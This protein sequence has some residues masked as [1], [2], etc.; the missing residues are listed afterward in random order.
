[1]Q[2]CEDLAARGVKDWGEGIPLIALEG[3]DLDDDSACV[4]RLRGRGLSDRTGP[5]AGSLGALLGFSLGPVGWF[6][7]FVLPDK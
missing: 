4:V 1:M 5:G 6:F 7:I 3:A 2:R